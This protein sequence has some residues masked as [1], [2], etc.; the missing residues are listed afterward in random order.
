V[1]EGKTAFITGTSR[2]IGRAILTTFAKNKAKIFAHARLETPEFAESIEKLSKEY[3]TEIIPIY[4]DLTD[5]DSMKN[6]IRQCIGTKQ[7]IDILVNNAG[8]AR[9]STSFLMT[10]LEKMKET[11][12]VN[13]FAQMLLTQYLAR[14]MIRQ[15][16]GSIINIS[17]VAAVAAEPG[18]L[19]YVASKAAFLSA[20]RKL[21]IEFAPY[22]VRVNSVLPG[23]IETDMGGQIEA[24]LKEQIISGTFMKRSGKTDEIA[25]SVLYLASELSSYVTGQA[26]RVDGGM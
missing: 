8:I 9:E 15:K 20:T 24:S 19:E 12:E 26:I 4:F 3:G 17:S 7:P 21:A 25:N 14:I 5:Y 2:G 10:S 23:I 1:L 16:S 13:F 11:F 6:K 18:Q 22:G